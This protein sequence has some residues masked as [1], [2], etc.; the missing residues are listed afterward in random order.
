MSNV[1]SMS[2]ATEIPAAVRALEMSETLPVIVVACVAV[3]EPAPVTY[4]SYVFNLAAL[5]E[6]TGVVSDTSIVNELD[7]LNLPPATLTVRNV[8][9]SL[10]VPVTLDAA[11]MS[12]EP[13]ILPAP[14]SA[15]RA[16]AS[17]VPSSSSVA[18]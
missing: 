7:G 10:S 4:K 17:K 11:V 8:S 3:T 16:D 15:F 12:T 13:R 5:T 1:T 9:S 2:L 18:S 6:V 14:N